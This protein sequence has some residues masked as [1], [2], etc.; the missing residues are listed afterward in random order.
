MLTSG[1]I[2][3]TE[4]Q[5]QQRLTQMDYRNQKFVNDIRTPGTCEWFLKLEKYV[6][7]AE[8]DQSQTLWVTAD[9]G[10]GKSVLC[11]FLIGTLQQQAA[12]LTTPATLCFFFFKNGQD[13]LQTGADLLCAILDSFSSQTLFL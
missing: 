8:S 1:E 5:S 9:P 7:W 13:G 4:T 3:A 10:C 12:S 11:S 6:K 2:D